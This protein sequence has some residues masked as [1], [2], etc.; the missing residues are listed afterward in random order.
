MDFQLRGPHKIQFFYNS[1]YKSIWLRMDH[2][3]NISRINCGTM[4]INWSNKGKEKK[5]GTKYGNTM[6]VLATLV[7]A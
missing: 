7:N 6:Y 1:K 3:I 2:L 4:E 5:N